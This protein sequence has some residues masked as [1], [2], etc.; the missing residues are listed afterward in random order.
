MP[1]GIFSWALSEQ[2]RPEVG[3]GVTQTPGSGC[4]AVSWGP[5]LDMLPVWSNAMEPSAATP[6]HI[7]TKEAGDR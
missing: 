1:G 2:K 7:P 3:W 5:L 6:V 4:W